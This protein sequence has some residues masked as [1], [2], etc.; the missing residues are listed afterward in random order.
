MKRF[1]LVYPVLQTSTP[2]NQLER[3]KS[4]AMDDTSI[5]KHTTT[6][7]QLKDIS[8]A[9]THASQAQNLELVLEQIANVSR[10]LVKARYAA[11][12]IPDDD[13]KL[14]HFKVSGISK[15]EILKIG[16]PP[17]GNGLLGEIIHG[18]ETI[19]VKSLSAHPKSSGFPKN[20]PPMTSFLG[21]P[22]QT[23]GDLLGSI[24]LTDR[25]DGEP[26][27]DEDRWIVEVMASYVAMAIINSTAREQQNRLAL[28]E[29]RERIAMELHD[30]VIQTMY[31]VGM[32]LNV[33]KTKGI[34]SDP[35]EMQPILD[36]LDQAVEDIRAYIYRLNTYQPESMSFYDAVEAVLDRLTFPSKL[37][38][39]LQAPDIPSSLS[40][41]GMENLLSIIYEGAS[42]VIRHADAT[43]L[44][45][46]VSQSAEAVRLEIID[47]GN[48]FDPA[49]LEESGGLGLK[50]IRRRA[51][52]VGG[53]VQMTSILGSGTQL[54]FFIPVRF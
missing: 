21:V 35:D 25:L 33:L 12:G 20:H 15:E 23:N 26:F 27:S 36:T 43:E 10:K 8:K 42:N 17:T 14:K 54:S 44:E 29:E 30:G 16:K 37:K 49:A 53:N 34:I 51:E 11:I 38:I 50:N 5:Q 47:N 2:D 19:K 6:L 3:N 40:S 7:R 46:R 31:A 48:G 24:Y 4:N 1:T 28:L 39:S 45:I 9:V 22:V 52:I 41:G 13:G 18:R 32:S